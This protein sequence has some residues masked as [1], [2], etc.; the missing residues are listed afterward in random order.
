MLF[1]SRLCHKFTPCHPTKGRADTYKI[2][3]A[4]DRVLRGA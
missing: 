1:S 2:K 4:Q 3:K